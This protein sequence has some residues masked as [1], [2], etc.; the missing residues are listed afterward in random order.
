MCHFENYK[1]HNFPQ[2]IA[3]RRYTLLTNSVY[4]YP[5]WC[6]RLQ[7]FYLRLLN[8]LKAVLLYPLKINFTKTFLHALTPHPKTFKE[9]ISWG[10]QIIRDIYVSNLCLRMHPGNKIVFLYVYSSRIP[11]K[12]NTMPG[13]DCNNAAVQEHPNT[14]ISRTPSLDD[15]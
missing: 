2:R 5:L 8:V 11:L 6:D 4:T 3:H 7:G 12:A 9:T 1:S 15:H 10:N 14:S 13:C